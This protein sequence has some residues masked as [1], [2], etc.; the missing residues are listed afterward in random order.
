V[1]TGLPSQARASDGG[2]AIGPAD[3][4][5]L[6]VGSADVTIGFQQPPALRD[7]LAKRLPETAGFAQLA[8]VE[9]SGEWRYIADLGAYEASNNHV[10]DIPTSAAV[11]AVKAASKIQ[12]WVTVRR[13]KAQP[14][15]P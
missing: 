11:S 2:N 10:P 8:R 7:A 3:I 12:P 5:M 4:S 13:H 9:P 1:A 6:G 15:D 14:A